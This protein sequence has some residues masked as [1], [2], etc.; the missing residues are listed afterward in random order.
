MRTRPARGDQLANTVTADCAIV[1]YVRTLYSR[2]RTL[3]FAFFGARTR[4][5][6]YVALITIANLGKIYNNNR[7]LMSAVAM[8]VVGL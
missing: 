1:A 8:P 4:D 2:A 7:V 5:H 6:T 3:A